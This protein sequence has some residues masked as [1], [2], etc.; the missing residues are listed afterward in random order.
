MCRKRGLAEGLAPVRAAS[1]VALVVGAS[2]MLHMLAAAAARPAGAQ[3][4]VVRIHRFGVDAAD[5]QPARVVSSTF[6]TL[7]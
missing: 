2:S 1:P 6:K 3:A 7:R 4:R 5:R